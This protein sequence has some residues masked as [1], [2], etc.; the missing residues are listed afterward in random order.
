M[1]LGIGLLVMPIATPVSAE[2]RDGLSAAQIRTIRM[3]GGN[4]LRARASAVQDPELAALRE[5]IKSLQ[6]ALREL[7]RPTL[8]P[9]LQPALGQE[10][11]ET[12]MAVAQAAVEQQV[13]ERR[14]AAERKVRQAIGRVRQKQ[15]IVTSRNL[16]DSAPQQARIRGRLSDKITVLLG[17]VENTLEDSSPGRFAR[18][19][20]LAAR[21]EVRRRDLHRPLNATPTLQSSIRHRRGQ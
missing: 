17:E 3:V 2:T 21:L 19:H 8:V 16:P 1:I 14:E 11:G 7:G 18:M 5:E 13:A 20:A 9:G 6:T 10:T 4:V 12:N 15:G